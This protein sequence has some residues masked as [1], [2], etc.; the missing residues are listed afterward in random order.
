MNKLNK[1]TAIINH[2]PIQHLLTPFPLNFFRSMVLAAVTCYKFTYS[3]YLLSLRFLTRPL[4]VSSRQ[5][6]F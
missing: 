5:K 2:A 3:L 4:N 6:G 1:P